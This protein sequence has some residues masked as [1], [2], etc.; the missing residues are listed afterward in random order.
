M[1]RVTW[2]IALLLK[3]ISLA[4]ILLGPGTARELLA[5]VTHPWWC[6]KVCDC[7]DQN[8]HGPRNTQMHHSTQNRWYHDFYTCL[9]TWTSKCWAFLLHICYRKT[10]VVWRLWLCDLLCCRRWHTTQANAHCVTHCFV[11]AVSYTPPPPPTNV[12]SHLLLCISIHS[13]PS[14]PKYQEI[15]T[16]QFFPFKSTGTPGS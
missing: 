12:Q 16:V 14:V 3:P 1:G 8:T 15:N 5:Q 9:Q 4:R 11:L 13:P 10:H 7:A 6:S 2:A